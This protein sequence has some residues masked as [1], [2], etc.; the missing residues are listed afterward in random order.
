M[1]L[2]LPIWSRP[3]ELLPKCCLFLPAMLVVVDFVFSAVVDDQM[4]VKKKT[5]ILISSFV[6]LP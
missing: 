5:K 3:I 2:H 6:Y 4:S 1:R